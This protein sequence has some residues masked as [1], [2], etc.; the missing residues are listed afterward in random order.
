MS[1]TEDA[2]NDDFEHLQGVT[3][4]DYRINKSDVEYKLA[5]PLPQQSSIFEDELERDDYLIKGE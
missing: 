5:E 2:L 4:S 3:W 1:V